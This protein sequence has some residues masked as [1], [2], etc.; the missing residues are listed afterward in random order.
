M[1]EYGTSPVLFILL[2]MFFVNNSSYMRIQAFFSGCCHAPHAS[3][4]KGF[5]K[6]PFHLSVFTVRC[7]FI[8]HYGMKDVSAIFPFP[9][10]AES[11]KKFS[12]K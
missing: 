2:F 5:A 7:Y 4:P 1:L 3:L 6:N 9:F 8:M 11:D 10:I 12:A